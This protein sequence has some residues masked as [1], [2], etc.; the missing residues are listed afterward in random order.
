[1]GSPEGELG[2]GYN[3]TQHHVT[4]TRDYWIGKYPV[5]QREYLAV[6]GENP[7][8]YNA[9]CAWSS[10]DN[11]LNWPVEMV[12]WKTAR[13]FCSRLNGRINLPAGYRFDLPTEA[14]WEYACRAGTATSLNN[15]RNITHEFEKCA[16][17]DKLGWYGENS[18]DYRS[19]GRKQPNAWGLYDMHGNVHEWCRDWYECE[20]ASDPEFLAGQ[21]KRKFRVARGGC[22]RSDPENCRSASRDCFEPKECDDDIGFRLALVPVK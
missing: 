16:N 1:M 19:V 17:L 6:M 18:A 4:L 3:E 2:K 21:K 5:T 13:M 9:D 7:S 12:S 14:Q 15:G 8:R 22:N 20:Y 10:D 11:C